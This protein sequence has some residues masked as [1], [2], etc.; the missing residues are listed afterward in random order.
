[1]SSVSIENFI[2]YYGS[3]TENTMF[4]LIYLLLLKAL[5]VLRGPW[6]TLMGFSIYI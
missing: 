1:M 5:T 6:P 4:Q 2:V 3:N